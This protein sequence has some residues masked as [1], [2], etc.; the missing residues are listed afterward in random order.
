MA[1]SF[2]D[3]LENSIL[4]HVYGNQAYTS[5]ST[6]F[7]GLYTGAPTDCGGGTEVSGGAYVRT[8]VL[9]DTANWPSAADGALSNGTAISF[10]TATA[11][12][13][14]V[15]AFGVFDSCA[16][17][18]LLS[19]ADLTVNKTINSGDAANFAIGDLDVTLD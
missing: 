12:W 3:F 4:N 7:V 9:N 17:G 11:D 8:S 13:G 1:G 19:W 18:N 5:P 16:A 14:T 2:S 10:S 6:M 15:V